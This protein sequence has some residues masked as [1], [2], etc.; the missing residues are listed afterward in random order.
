MLNANAPA[1]IAISSAALACACCVFSFFLARRWRH[2]AQNHLALAHGF[3][4]EAEEL[5]RDLDLV[6]QRCS[7]AHR[8][9]AWLESRVR[10]NL[11]SAAALAPPAAETTYA[12]IPEKIGV[13]ERRHRVLQLARR[14]QDAPTI[15]RTLNLPNGE[16]EL[17][18]S[19]SRAA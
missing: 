5:S 19:L 12:A 11:T 4:R 6:T 9:L 16:V 15:A 10:S 13:T 2:T 8:R 17:I 7:D 18:M 3:E 14:G 1:I